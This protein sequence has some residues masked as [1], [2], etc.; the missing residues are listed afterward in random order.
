[1]ERNKERVLAYSLAQEISDDQLS[2]VAGGTAGATR[3]P[4]TADTFGGRDHTW[5]SDSD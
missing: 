4:T 1:M 3:R 2:E 5:D